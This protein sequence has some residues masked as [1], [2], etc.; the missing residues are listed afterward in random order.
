MNVFAE[1]CLTFD[2]RERI[3]NISSELQR[4]LFFVL[5]RA[6]VAS[7]NAF[8]TARRLSRSEQRRNA[9]K[10]NGGIEASFRRVLG[11]IIQMA[12]E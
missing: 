1:G 6:C 3:K 12:R 8:E 7:I 2:S 10:K 11:I 9:G 5:F 4:N